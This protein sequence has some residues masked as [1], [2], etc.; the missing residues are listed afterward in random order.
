V[1]F[2]KKLSRAQKQRIEL[3]VVVVQKFETIGRFS[4]PK[5]DYLATDLQETYFH[6]NS[7]AK[8]MNS[9]LDAHNYKLVWT[10]TYFE[11]YIP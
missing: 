2:E 10:N 1:T 3:P 4:D 8:S 11:I 5:P 6:N 9:F 7:I